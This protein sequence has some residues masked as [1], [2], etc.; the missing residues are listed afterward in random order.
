MQQA[1]N[2]YNRKVLIGNWKEEQ[3]LEEA[4][5]QNFQKRTDDGSGHWKKM[6]I[7]MACCNTPVA[8]SYNEDETLRFGDTVVMQHCLSGNV[9]AC[10]PFDEVMIGQQ[11]YQVAGSMQDP[12]KPIARMTFTITRPPTRLCGTF[13]DPEDPFVRI[14]QAFQLVCSDSLLTTAYSNML[15]P[16]LYLSSTKKNERTASKGTNKQMVFMSPECGADS[17]WFAA[18]PSQGRKNGCERL[19]KIGN[20]ITQIDELLL[21]HRQTNMLLTLDTKNSSQTDFGIESECFADRA[22]A[23]GKLGLMVSEA[24]GYSTP[25]T[26]TK[27]DAPIFTWIFVQAKNPSLAEFNAEL[28]PKATVDYLLNLLREDVEIAGGIRELSDFFDELQEKTFVRGKMERDDLIAALTTFLGPAMSVP[29]NLL[30]GLLNLV[31]TDKIG[32]IDVN[33]FIRLVQNQ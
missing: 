28:P 4:K 21:N 25:A 3:A 17:V 15:S 32:L 23:N 1:T 27:P 7:K 2:T 16:S 31:D 8:L 20:P 5:A 30:D 33:D 19:L 11:K 24:Q 9:L 22:A 12:Q 6:Q 18:V 29:A 13:D 26:L 14:G 10:D